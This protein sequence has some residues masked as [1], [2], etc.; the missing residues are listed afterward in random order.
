MGPYFVCLVCV[1][2]KHYT[3]FISKC[4]AQLRQKKQKVFEKEGGRMQWFSGCNYN[5]PEATTYQRL[6]V[7]SQLSCYSWDI[8]L[9]AFQCVICI[10]SEH[11]NGLYWQKCTHEVWLSG[12]VPLWLWGTTFQPKFVHTFLVDRV[13]KVNCELPIKLLLNHAPGIFVLEFFNRNLSI[14]FCHQDQNSA[15]ILSLKSR[16]VCMYIFQR[17]LNPILEV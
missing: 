15:T 1:L 10:V 12:T 13:S 3:L 11:K 9:K 2:R 5:V 16:F 8:C 6:I 7:D 4:W 14:H 17:L